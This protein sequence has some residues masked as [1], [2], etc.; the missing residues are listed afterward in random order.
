M[1]VVIPNEETD[2]YWNLE[3]DD[4]RVIP[5]PPKGVDKVRRWFNAKEPIAL[6]DESIPFAQVTGFSK[7]SRR[8]TDVKLIED[9]ARAF[10]EPVV[11][12]E[13][14][15][16]ARWVKKHVTRKEYDKYYAK[17]IMYKYLTD[18][19]GMVAVAIL[20]PVHMIDPQVHENCTPEEAKKL[21]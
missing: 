11:T 3:L 20:L 15:V 10:N 1:S 5:I 6:R 14:A 7:S 8:F 18:T 4:G 19:E 16:K 17:S 13:G 9:T 21:G 2:Y 12:E